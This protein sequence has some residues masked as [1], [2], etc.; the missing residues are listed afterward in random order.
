MILAQLKSTRCDDSLQANLTDFSILNKFRDIFLPEQILDMPF[1]LERVKS[2]TT[3][4][5]PSSNVAFSKASLNKEQ[6]LAYE[7]I[8]THF[9]Q[10]ITKPIKML[11]T[12]QGG[13]GKSYVINGLRELLGNAGIICSYFGIAAHNIRG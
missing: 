11:I 10:N 8:V 13:S 1:W 2:N 4:P 9:L 12:G 3:L 5:P 6:L 7:L